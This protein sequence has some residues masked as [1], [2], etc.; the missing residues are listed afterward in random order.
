MQTIIRG[1]Q[2]WGYCPSLEKVKKTETEE[3]VLP[4]LPALR[5][6]PPACR[7]NRAGWIFYSSFG[8]CG[9]C[10]GCS[11]GFT[12][13]SPPV[14]SSYS[15]LC[16]PIRYLSNHPTMCC[17]RSMRCHGWPERESSC[18]SPGNRTI[19]VGRLRNLSARNISSPPASGGVR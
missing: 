7:P 16:I 10:C 5:T 18:D 15:G 2:F 13:I 14:T 6:P 19:T 9:G 12:L 8:G 3:Q 11:V 4:D 1:D 17:K